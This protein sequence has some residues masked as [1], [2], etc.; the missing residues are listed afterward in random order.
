MKLKRVFLAGTLV[1]LLCLSGAKA[2]P[3]RTYGIK[4]GVVGANESW[5]VLGESD[6]P[7]DIRWGFTAD[8]YA[9]L[10]YSKYLSADAEIQY[11]QKGMKYSIPVTTASQPDG[12]GQYYTISPR[13]DYISIPILAKLRLPLA[14]VAPYL[15]IGPR[16]DFL[17]SRSG[18]SLDA[19]ISQFD[20]M[21]YGLTLGAGVEL[22][23]IFPYGLLAEFRYNF[24]SY[25][26]YKSQYLSVRNRSMDFLVGVRL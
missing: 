5:S 7:T 24:N 16:F 2:Q 3:A 11:T 15:I 17:I 8:V 9:E 26:S 1:L 25:D 21:D 22:N 6:W 10:P 23:S 13:I 4:L 14:A 20:R 19:A 18:G 12:S